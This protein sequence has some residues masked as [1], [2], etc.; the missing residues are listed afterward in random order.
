M[1]GLISF[2]TN[3]TQL[4]EEISN[5][6][7]NINDCVMESKINVLQQMEALY[8]KS[9]LIMENYTNDDLFE[10]FDIFNEQSIIF[11]ENA[12]VAVEGLSHLKFDN[13]HILN[14]I[15]LF[16]EARNKFPD[17]DNKVRVLKLIKTKEFKQGIKELE[18]QFQCKLIISGLMGMVTGSA[19]IPLPMAHFKKV[20]ISKSKGFQL[21]G[22]PILIGIGSNQ[23]EKLMIWSSKETFG[24]SLAAVLLHE[25][26]H[27]ISVVLRLKSSEIMAATSTIANMPSNMTGEQR[28]VM[29]TNYVET[30]VKFMDVKMSKRKKKKLIKQLAV[31]TCVK[32]DKKALKKLKGNPEDFNNVTLSTKD[33]ENTI[34]SAAINHKKSK[35]ND[36]VSIIRSVL[37]VIGSAVI[38]NPLALLVNMNNI[39][40]ILKNMKR[41]YSDEPDYEEYNA[42]LFA[43]MYQLPVSFKY[44][45]KDVQKKWYG[46]KINYKPGT[47]NQ[48]DKQDLEVRSKLRKLWQV[49]VYDVHPGNDERN[50]AAYKSAKNMLD[51]GIELDPEIRKYLE[52]IV[53]NFSSLDNLNLDEIYDEKLFNP[54]EVNMIDEHLNNMIKSERVVVTEADI[55][56]INYD[57]DENVIVD[58]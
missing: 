13:T 57:A 20:T 54:Q 34:K 33:V 53:S 44:I 7:A 32:L 46:E 3:E 19:T 15:R 1:K 10:N 50:Y 28:R 2:M 8:E 25:I 21:N 11:V 51:S 55:S 16:N 14:A 40:V 58:Y 30:I 49:A 43:S 5:A 42:D 4:R 6:I 38:F 37:G 56:F 26:W 22:L 27:N 48:L 12:P 35:Q 24:Q 9:N 23:N 41:K 36:V 31:M 47:P 17:D 29:I 18:Q 39:K 45:L 52:W